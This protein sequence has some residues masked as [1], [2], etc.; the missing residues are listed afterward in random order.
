MGST[1]RVFVG[2]ALAAA[3]CSDDGRE[4]DVSMTATGIGSIDTGGTAMNDD[5]IDPTDTFKLD[6]PGGEEGTGAGDEAGG[7]GCE[8]VDFLF[9]IDN[10]GSMSDDQQALVANFPNFIAGIE[11]TLETVDSFHVGVVTTDAYSQNT[12]GCNQLGALVT[13][14][15][16]GNCG[17]YTEGFNF[18]TEA[19]NLA[20]AFACAGLVGIN[21]SASERQMEAMMRAVDGTHGMM[22]GCNYQFVREDALLVI[23]IITDEPDN[24]SVGG[25]IDWYN[26][27]VA[28]KFGI[29]ENI[30]VVSIINTPNGQ[31]GSNAVDIAAFTNM[32]GINGYMSDICLQNFG[33]IFDQAIAIIDV[34]CDNYLQN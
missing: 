16:Q 31:C 29:P 17:P 22:G 33:P 9:V 11:A 13:K 3:A 30:V 12:P 27:V 4:N 19:D 26:T 23:I 8:K 18:M 6:S 20:Q 5:G 32:F 25:P 7:E 24:A 14:T 2:L 10:S 21:G 34:A 1:V 28:A 15:N